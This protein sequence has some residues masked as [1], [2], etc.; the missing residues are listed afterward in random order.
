M[1][2]QFERDWE[3]LPLPEHWE[4]RVDTRTGMP[5]YL[6]H[7]KQFTTWDDP[8]F[9]QDPRGM[10]N[11]MGTMTRRRSVSPIPPSSWRK[12]NEDGST[13]IPF[14]HH[15]IPAESANNQYTQSLPRSRRHNQPAPNREP[16]GG[17]NWFKTGFSEPGD[18]FFND[19]W[20]AKSHSMR[21]RSQPPFG[22]DMPVSQTRNSP[23][24]GSSL[25]RETSAKPPVPTSS[26]TAPNQCPVV[27]IPVNTEFS[28]S[29][30][31]RCAREQVI[32][33]S[34]YKQDKNGATADQV[35]RSRDSPRPKLVSLS[36]LT[37]LECQ[38]YE[39]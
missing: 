32:V 21:M 10:L 2:S 16:L 5:Y 17:D 1:T 38:I 27:T 9:V 31:P 37:V 30:D 18:N 29:E 25:R 34:Q 20:P 35:T 24:L 28:S 19:S 4:M 15:F 22:Y 12:V 14:D 13:S 8:R 6:N 23:P 3:S 26:Q 39:M 11:P 33:P 36:V 7:L